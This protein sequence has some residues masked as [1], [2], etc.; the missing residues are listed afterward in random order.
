LW[1][2]A[3]ST[4]CVNELTTAIIGLPKSL[5]FMPEAAGRPPY[6]GRE[7]WCENGK[8]AWISSRLS[9]YG[10]LQVRAE[11]PGTDGPPQFHIGELQ[12]F[13]W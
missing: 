7:L 1:V 11:L 10:A 12:L 6:S 8:L 5:F 9:D 2:Q 3:V 13:P 4:N